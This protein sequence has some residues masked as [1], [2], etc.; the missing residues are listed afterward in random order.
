LE[1]SVSGNHCKADD[2][3]GYTNRWGAMASKCSAA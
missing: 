2:L 1:L 3:F